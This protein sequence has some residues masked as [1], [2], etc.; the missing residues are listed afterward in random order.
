M[1]DT[2]SIIVY[3]S[4]VERDMYEGI[5]YIGANYPYHLIGGLVGFIALCIFMSWWQ[6]VGSKMW[7][8]WWRG[9]K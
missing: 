8:K 6:D 2:N 4:P 7:R 3:R 1:G 5:Y 9:E